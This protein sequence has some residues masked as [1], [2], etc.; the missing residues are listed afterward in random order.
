MAIKAEKSGSTD[1]LNAMSES[2]KIGFENYSLVKKMEKIYE[3]DKTQLAKLKEK[4]ADTN[5]EAIKSWIEDLEHK[6][7]NEQSSLN[8]I[9]MRSGISTAEA[10]GE[11]FTS[12]DRISSYVSSFASHIN[13]DMDSQKEIVYKNA[14]EIGLYT[15]AGLSDGLNESIENVTNTC[16]NAVNAVTSSFQKLFEI[17]SPSKL[18]RDEVG[19][20]ILP[21]I[22]VGIDDTVSDTAISMNDSIDNLMSQIDIPTADKIVTGFQDILSNIGINAVPQYS[23]VYVQTQK[24]PQS[25]ESEKAEIVQNN[26][27]NAPEISIFIGDE[28]I[29]N[30]VVSTLNEAN[31]VSGGASF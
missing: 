29:K 25:K 8:D 11:G 26:S 2:E 22:A 28:E 7:Y 1:F 5:S 13:S 9:Y 4:Y 19:K 16:Q 21:G 3:N 15:G 18:M 17:H 6:V 31:A 30:F 14:K 24:N 23:D 10:F 20:W 27:Q 12:E